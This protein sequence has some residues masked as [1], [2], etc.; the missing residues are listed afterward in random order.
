[1]ATSLPTNRVV[2]RA[3]IAFAAEHKIGSVEIIDNDVWGDGAKAFAWRITAWAKRNGHP[4]IRVS[5]RKTPELVSLV[6]PK[7]AYKVLQAPDAILRGG[8]RSLNAIDWIVIHDGELYLDDAGG[9]KVD[10][11]AEAMGN[12]FHSQA[13]A[14]PHYGVD[15][16]SIRQYC[17]LEIVGYHCTAFNTNTVGIEQGGRAAWPRT[18]WFKYCDPQLDRLAWLIGILSRKL[19][20]P[21]VYRSGSYIKKV[22]VHPG[23]AKGGVTTHLAHTVALCPGDHTDPG[24][25]F[26]MGHVLSLARSYAR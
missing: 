13:V 3:M 23:K 10:N 17:P 14:S 8:K 12:Y 5:T 7:P 21:I 19:D 9:P 6:V 24:I 16:D 11:A 22:G 25:N 26:P 4:T 15:N 20:I 18:Y 2:K 1:M